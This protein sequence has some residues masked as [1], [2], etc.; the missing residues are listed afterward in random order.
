MD[1]SISGKVNIPSGE[2]NKITVSGRVRLYGDVECEDF[3]ATG[4]VM[5]EKIDCEGIFKLSGIASFSEGINAESIDACGKLSC[6]G[7]LTAN[8]SFSISGS[9]RIA[10]GVKCEEISV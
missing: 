3:S 9:A 5:G 10:Q 6:K 4:A 2:Y 7:D 8:K 1:M